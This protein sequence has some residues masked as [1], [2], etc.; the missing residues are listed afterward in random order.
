[1]LP[2]NRHEPEL[3]SPLMTSRFVLIA[4]GIASFVVTLILSAWHGGLWDRSTEPPVTAAQPAPLPVL[5]AQ[6]AQKAESPP[7]Q[8]VVPE[9]VPAGTPAPAPT[10]NSSAA[11]PDSDGPADSEPQRRERQ[12]EAARGARTR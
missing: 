1:M 4:V 8:P 11:D 6:P 7:V 12:R 2:T 3:T 9:P 10:D 5:A